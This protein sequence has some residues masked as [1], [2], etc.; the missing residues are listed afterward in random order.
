MV[1]EKQA[2]LLVLAFVVAVYQVRNALTMFEEQD[3]VAE[4]AMKKAMMRISKIHPDVSFF[5]GEPW[6]PKFSQQSKYSVVNRALFIMSN[7]SFP[8]DQPRLV[9]E[10]YLDP[11][12]RRQAMED[13]KRNTGKKPNKHAYRSRD[14]SKNSILVFKVHE[15]RMVETANELMKIGYISRIVEVYPV[16]IEKEKGGKTVEVEETIVEVGVGTRSQDTKEETIAE[17]EESIV[18]VGVR[19]RSQDTKEET[20]AE[21]EEIIVEVGVGTRSQDTKEETI[22]EVEVE[23]NSQDDSRCETNM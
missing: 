23:V 17:E 22:V 21:E 19:T 9:A 7:P 14:K 8:T 6:S 18:E 20:I 16:S 11:A 15:K 5:F 2:L 3:K 13:K 12:R 4:D 10:L 1:F